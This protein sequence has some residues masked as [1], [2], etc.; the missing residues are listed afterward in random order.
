LHKKRTLI[1]QGSK[2][3]EVDTLTRD[4]QLNRITDLHDFIQAQPAEITVFDEKMVNRLIQKITVFENYFIV[5][6]K[7]GV[8]VEIEG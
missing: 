3:A 6:F 2:Q 7:S 5:E 8:E 4:E 1:S